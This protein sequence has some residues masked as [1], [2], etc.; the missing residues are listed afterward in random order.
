M[1]ALQ[2]WFIR[3]FLFFWFCIL[4][5]ISFLMGWNFL[6]MTSRAIITIMAVNLVLAIV[7]FSSI[8]GYMFF[9]D[10]GYVTRFV[11]N[12]VN[13]AKCMMHSYDSS[14]SEDTMTTCKAQC[15]RMDL[16]LCKYVRTSHAKKLLAECDLLQASLAGLDKLG[17]A[18][19]SENLKATTKKMKEGCKSSISYEVN[20]GVGLYEDYFSVPVYVYEFNQYLYTNITK[21]FTK[22]EN[23]AH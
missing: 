18:I 3:E 20:K 7:A 2:W 13:D 15:R 1:W 10:D 17:L 11:R 22:N 9:A 23:N 6:S 16:P 14:P 4:G 5:P 21:N 19:T 12:Q 8:L